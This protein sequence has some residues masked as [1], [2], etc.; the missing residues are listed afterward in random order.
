MSRKLL[1]AIA[2]LMLLG[3]CTTIQDY[4]IS[5]RNR[6]WS[7]YAWFIQKPHVRAKTGAPKPIEKHYGEGWRTGYRDVCHGGK[8][9]SV[10]LFPPQKYWGVQYQNFLGSDE[11]RAWFAGWKDG[12][13][14]AEADGTKIWVPL[15]C[16]GGHKLAIARAQAEA[17]PE[18]QREPVPM[19]EPLEIPPPIEELPPAQ[20]ENIDRETITK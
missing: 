19:G 20:T 10:P 4:T 15:P 3:G 7:W 12:A 17:G 14:A 9:E 13:K 18:P 6:Y 16:S 2:G 11:I 5:Q 1:L 8:S